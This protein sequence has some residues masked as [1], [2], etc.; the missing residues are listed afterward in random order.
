MYKQGEVYTIIYDIWIGGSL[1][2]V[3]KK[4][5]I[6]SLS[7]KE[8]VAGSDTATISLSDPEF[9]FIEDNIF[10]NDAKVKI[11]L[12]WSTTTYRV[13]FDGYISAIDIDFSND[14]I[15]ILTITCMDNTHIMNREKK[16]ETY[17]NTT[18]ASVVQKI[19]QSYGFKCQIDDSY[20]FAEQE[21]ITQSNQSDIDFITSLASKEVYPFTARLVGDTFYYVKMGN[22]TTP[23]MSLA[24]REYPHDVISFSPQ[25][26]KET[27][28]SGISNSSTDTSTKSTSD[29]ENGNNSDNQHGN[30]DNTD[31]KLGDNT[32]TGGR[33]AVYNPTT[34]KWSTETVAKIKS[35]SKKLVSKS[36]KKGLA[37][38][39][40]GKLA[41]IVTKPASG[42]T[43]SLGT[44]NIWAGLK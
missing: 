14:G 34:K 21:T 18:S 12:G 13:E 10:V 31:S 15:P 28:Q 2:D 9:L 35:R 33:K 23:V 25:I 32:E 36:K 30:T 43:K 8:T 1:L 3:A 44:K 37:K 39:V 40:S 27:K 4:Q 20:E 5:C 17:S 26:N 41:S 7:I 11:K 42:G 16:S 22:L 6:T 29:N 38:K 19:V 24:Y